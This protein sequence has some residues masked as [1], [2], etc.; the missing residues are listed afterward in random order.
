[1]D[2]DLELAGSELTMKAPAG[3]RYTRV[4]ESPTV[5]YITGQRVEFFLDANGLPTHFVMTIVE[6]DMKAVRK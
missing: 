3:G 5:F 6:G 2:Y 1:M 4:P